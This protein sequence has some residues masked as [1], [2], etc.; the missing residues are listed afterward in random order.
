M[1]REALQVVAIYVVVVLGAYATSYLLPGFLG[2][3]TAP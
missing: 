2:W 3:L 1:S